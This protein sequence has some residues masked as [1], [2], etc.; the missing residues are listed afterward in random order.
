MA[1]AVGCETII[2]YGSTDWRRTYPRCKNA[3]VVSAEVPCQPCWKRSCP[4]K[5]YLCLKAITPELI[6]KII[7]KIKEGKIS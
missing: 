6:L 2:I 7:E 1:A 3:Y 4:R 5:D